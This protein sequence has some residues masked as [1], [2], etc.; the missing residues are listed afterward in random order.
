LTKISY[1]GPAEKGHTVKKKIYVEFFR[2]A[3]RYKIAVPDLMEILKNEFLR[4]GRLDLSEHLAEAD[5]ILKGAILDFND[6]GWQRGSVGGFVSQRTYARLGVKFYER[7]NKKNLFYE[8]EFE[9]YISNQVPA[10]GLPLMGYQSGEL[11]LN[12][13]RKI[14][15]KVVDDWLPASGK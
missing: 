4:N 14:V 5:F 11:F 8:Q 2:A 15:L 10:Q 6:Q 7:K 12:L 9:D 13:S 1:K 3:P